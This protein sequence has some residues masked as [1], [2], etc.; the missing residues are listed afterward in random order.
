M[1]SKSAPEEYHVVESA[2]FRSA[3]SVSHTLS[4]VA[5]SEF[6]SE[7]YA[8]D[9]MTERYCSIPAE[10]SAEV[11]VCWAL[12]PV[13]SQHVILTEESPLDWSVL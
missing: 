1:P 4:L 9:V 13:A 11:I 2:S 7:E 10:T 12:H 6:G 3:A 8:W 5:M